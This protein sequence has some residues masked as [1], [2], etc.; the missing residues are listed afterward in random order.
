M[1]DILVAEIA[2]DR[3]GILAGV[4]QLVAGGVADHMRVALKRQAGLLTGL[5]D[6]PIEAVAIERG[7][8]L[9]DKDEG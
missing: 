7:A 9:I 1:P 5:V 2:L 3:A 6:H 4:R 8:A